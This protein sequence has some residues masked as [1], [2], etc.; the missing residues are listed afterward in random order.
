MNFIQN[1]FD[2]LFKVNKINYSN[3]DFTFFFFYIYYN[4]F[5]FITSSEFLF[6][7]DLHTKENFLS[8]HLI[9]FLRE[10][11]KYSK[12]F[13]DIYLVFADNNL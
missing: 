2:I 12:T 7:W 1:E 5:I 9:I 3:T 4:S 6:K 10:N 8:V 11:R 13:C